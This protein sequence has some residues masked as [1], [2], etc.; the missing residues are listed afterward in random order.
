MWTF[1]GDLNPNSYPSHPTSTYTCKKTTTPRL[2]VSYWV[3]LKLS[4]FAQNFAIFDCNLNVILK[5]FIK[6]CNLNHG[7]MVCVESGIYLMSFKSFDHGLLIC[8]HGWE[9]KCHCYC[10]LRKKNVDALLCTSIKL[11]NFK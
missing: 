11:S 4:V 7:L 9:F 10:S 6:W 1:F 5:T 3:L 2:R 8:S